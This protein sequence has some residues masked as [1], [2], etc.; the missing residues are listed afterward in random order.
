[1]SDSLAVGQLHEDGRADF[2]S[3]GG[4]YYWSAGE[5]DFQSAGWK[6]APRGGGGQ[7]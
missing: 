1:M 4:V 7:F 3:G 2:W 5:A 6:P